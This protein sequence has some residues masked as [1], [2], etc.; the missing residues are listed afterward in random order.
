VGPKI[1]GHFEVQFA[2]SA[3]ALAFSVIVFGVT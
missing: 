3:A 1:I 2:F